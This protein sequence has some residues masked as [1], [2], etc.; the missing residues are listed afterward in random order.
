MSAE[1]V[2]MEELREHVSDASSYHLPDFIGH[3]DLPSIGSF[4]LTKCMVVECFAALLAIALF[5][6][7]AAKMKSGKPVRGRLW[8]LLEATLLY[9]RNEV[10]VPSIGKKDADRFA[11]FLWTLFFFIL[12]CNL[13]GLI[14]WF[15]ASPTG[16]L[17]T[18]AVLSLFVF[19][20]L[21]CS[22]MKKFG[23]VGFWLGQ[24]PEMDLPFVL[25]IFLKPMLFVIEVVGMIIKHVVL[26]VRLL[27]NMFA[28]HLVIAVIMGFISAVA[29]GSA[30]LWG[31]VAFASVLLSVAL[32]MLELFV[33]FLQ[34]YIFMF[35]ASIYIGMAQH[36]H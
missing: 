20:V 22:G 3:F 2:N 28:G 8:N 10:I 32:N 7:L 34:A 26:A 24:V 23:I 11:P 33:A 12:F 13:A 30:L 14:P 18:T 17:A 4:A 36:K 6:P 27:A 15:G 19:L 21:I 1:L 9:L 25:A 29:G 35:L 31:G 16:S 5:V